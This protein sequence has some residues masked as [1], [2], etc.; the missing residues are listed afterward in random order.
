[1]S[2]VLSWQKNLLARCI[3]GFLVFA[4]LTW[5]MP[6]KAEAYIMPADQLVGLMMA[7]FSRLK[8]LV[9]THTAHLY[10][11][12]DQEADTV[13][14]ERIWLK[15]P[16]LFR[17]ELMGRLE[18]QG[19][20]DRLSINMAFRRLLMANDGQSIMTL[21]LEMGINRESM[22]FTRFN[23]TIAY[24]IGDKSP[25]SP[26]LLIEKERFLPLL[27]SYRVPGD[28]GQ[29]MLTVQFD[30]YRK[31][32]EGWYPHQISYM[33]GKDISARYFIIDVQVNVPVDSSLMRSIR[34]LTRPPQGLGN[35]KELH[36]E[37]R[38][39]EVIK[40]LKEKYQ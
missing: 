16:G 38:L 32:P 3:L 10:S 29:K 26:K 6:Y 30:D 35:G 23:G 9:I 20:G 37:E 18:G 31:L 34:E 12:Q 11:S 5:V 17:V 7:N 27:I 15:S 8:S 33:A 4:A 25:Q 24:R 28:P 19:S 39:R 13:L 40:L 36:D 2:F 21:L 22:G 14:E 1:V